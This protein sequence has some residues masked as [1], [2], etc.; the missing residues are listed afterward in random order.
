MHRDDLLPSLRLLRQVP[1]AGGRVDDRAVL[2]RDRIG[3]LQAPA[4]R[5]QDLLQDG[6]L[7]ILLGRDEPLHG[8][9]LPSTACPAKVRGKAAVRGGTDYIASHSL[10]SSLNS[11]STW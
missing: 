3:V 1:G 2:E 9:L 5:P 8:R 6:T 11:A 10:G 4:Q 7:H